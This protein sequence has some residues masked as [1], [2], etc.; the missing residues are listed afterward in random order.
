MKRL[1]AAAMILAALCLLTL[2]GQR[3]VSDSLDSLDKGLARVESLCICGEYPQAREQIRYM[4]QGYQKQ[5]A[6]LAVFVRKDQLHEPESALYG[7]NAYAHPDYL[8]DLL[9]ETGKLKSQLNGVRR[10]FFGLL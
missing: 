8:Q 7:L 6:V 2:I 1:R 10:L 5:Q 9:C 3:L 4:T